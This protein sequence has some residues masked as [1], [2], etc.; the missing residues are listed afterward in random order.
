[1]VI[2]AIIVIF[3]ISFQSCEANGKKC[4]QYGHSCLGGHGKRSEELSSGVVQHFSELQRI[5]DPL[6]ERMANLLRLMIGQRMNTYQRQA[7]NTQQNIED[8]DTT[9]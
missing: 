2:Y 7:E 9:N 8:F 4:Q 5:N 1:M 3:S 6:L